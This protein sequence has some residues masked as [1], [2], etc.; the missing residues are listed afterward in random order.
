MS[1]YFFKIEIKS[2]S[3]ND[4]LKLFLFVLRGGFMWYFIKRAYLSDTYTRNYKQKNEI[5]LVQM[6]AQKNKIN[7]TTLRISSHQLF[8]PLLES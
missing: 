4:G 2:F 8:L 1:N 6:M 3:K 5:L 7:L